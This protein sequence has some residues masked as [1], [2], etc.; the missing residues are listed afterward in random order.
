MKPWSGGLLV[1]LGVFLMKGPA[2]GSDATLF[3]AMGGAAVLQKSVDRFT[4]IVQADDRINFAFAEAD[5][6]KFNRLLYEQLCEI[7]GGPCHYTG[8]DMHSAHAKLHVTKA[9]FN[10]LAEDLYKALSSAGVPYRQQNRLMARLAP[11][12]RQIVASGH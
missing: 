9:Q 4:D 11:M 1:C 12:E 3:A 7:S 10:A 2:W 8:R 6:G 5:I